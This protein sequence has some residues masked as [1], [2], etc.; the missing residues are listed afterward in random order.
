MGY[1]VSMDT[2]PFQR[3][4]YKLEK[5]IALVTVVV[6]N[7]VAQQIDHVTKHSLAS[8]TSVLGKRNACNFETR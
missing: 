7:G 8:L 1:T 3:C 5:D 4:V 2:G 6:A